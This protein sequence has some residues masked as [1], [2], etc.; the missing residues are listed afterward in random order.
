MIIID[1]FAAFKDQLQ[2]ENRS[3]IKLAQQ[4]RSLGILLLLC[5]QEPV[6]TVDQDLRQHCRFQISLRARGVREPWQ[7]PIGSAS[8]QVV[9][10]TDF[11][12]GY[13]EAPYFPVGHFTRTSTN[14]QKETIFSVNLSQTKQNQS[15][16]IVEKIKRTANEL[17]DHLTP[18]G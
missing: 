11:Q 5:T 17:Q 18:G 12:C 8:F 1:E 15:Q 16:A 13:P 7:L 14:G 2:D 9:E 3:L 6:A 10:N 4:G